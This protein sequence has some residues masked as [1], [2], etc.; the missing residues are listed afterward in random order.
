MFSFIIT[1]IINITLKYAKINQIMES[2]LTYTMIANF[3]IVAMSTRFYWG[4]HHT[5]LRLHI[6]RQ[7][8][9][10]TIALKNQCSALT[11]TVSLPWARVNQTGHPI[12][13]FA[14]GL[15]G[16]DELELLDFHSEIIGTG[17]M[18]RGSQSVVGTRI[19]GLLMSPWAS[20]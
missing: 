5:E 6:P 11:L 18:G 4:P 14:Y 19:T 7:T 8:A 20:L 12:H 1:K 9:P 13:G 10:S 2:V 3:P 17:I 15:V 16:K